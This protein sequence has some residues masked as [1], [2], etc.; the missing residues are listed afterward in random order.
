MMGFQAK[1]AAPIVLGHPVEKPETIATAIRIGNPASWKLAENARDESGGFIGMVS[2]EEIMAA[3]SLM[4]T[5][6]GVFGEPASAAPLAGLLK[7][8]RKGMDFSSKKIVCVVTG[9][10]LKDSDVVLKNAPP[11]LELPPDLAVVEQ[12]LGWK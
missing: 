5:K 6:A 2:D 12:A 8:S 11:F 3:H 10:G 4:A 1:G 9:N 7:L